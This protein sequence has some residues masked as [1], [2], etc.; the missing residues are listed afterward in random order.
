MQKKIITFSFIA[1]LAIGLWVSVALSDEYITTVTC[2]V[3]FID[4]PQNYSIGSTSNGEVYLQ[5]KGKGWE[6]AKL[7][8]GG[9]KEF[10]ISVKRRIGRFRAD[11][12][13]YVK[14][15]SWLSDNFQVLEILPGQIEYEIEKVNSKRVKVVS[16]L[17]IDFKTDFAATSKMVIDP[18]YIEISG[19]LTLLK[20]IDSISTIEKSFTDISENFL[21]QLPLSEITGLTYSHKSCTIRMEVQKIVD[22]SFEEIPVIIKNMP[23]TKE[24]VLYPSKIN[25]VLRGGI[26]KLGRLTNDSIS[27]YVDYW[28]ALKN[29][30]N[31]IEPT[32]QIPSFTSLVSVEPKQ[33]DYIIK[34]Y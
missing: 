14:S 25:L 11:I 12:S 23:G 13:T 34:Q 33:L 15:N 6:L 31:K 3:N 29:S 8:I 30:N 21:V 28:G 9:S 1:I 10:N 27:A 19:P 7:V 32:I 18:E 22:K 24:L 20:K 16:A 5:L 17:K 26:N 2:P 4:L